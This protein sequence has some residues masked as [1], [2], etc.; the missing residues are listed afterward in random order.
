MLLTNLQ[1][2]VHFSINPGPLP[3]MASVTFRAPLRLGHASQDLPLI[4]PTGENEQDAEGCWIYKGGEWYKFV[5]IY[6]DSWEEVKERTQ[7]LVERVRQEV[8]SLARLQW[9]LFHSLP[10]DLAYVFP[11]Q[12]E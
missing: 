3:C 1:V 7:E 4:L 11:I 5:S 6:G 12:E 9:K 2:N 8:E 10:A